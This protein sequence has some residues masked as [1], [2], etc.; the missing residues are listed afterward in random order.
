MKFKKLTLDEDLTDW[1]INMPLKPTVDQP[2]TKDTFYEIDD[3]YRAL[4]Y[5]ESMFTS[6]EEVKPGPQQGPD[7]GIADCIMTA[8]TEEF[9]AIKSYNSIIATMQAEDVSKYEPFVKVLQDIAAEENLHVGQLQEILKKI[10]PNAEGIEDGK[11]EAH[12]QLDNTVCDPDD[13][14]CTVEN[15]DDEM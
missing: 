11:E 8:I 14:M 5:P 10:S 15:V 7:V 6:D 13:A 1:S 3:D 2:E 12:S 9:A 4:D